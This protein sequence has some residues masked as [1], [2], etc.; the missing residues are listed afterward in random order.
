M[1]ANE[2][3]IAGLYM[4]LFVFM[5]AYFLLN[6]IL[7][8]ILSNFGEVEEQIA[9]EER[10]EAE[11]ELQRQ[12][13]SQQKAAS[14]GSHPP[15]SRSNTPREASNGPR[16]RNE[17]GRTFSGRGQGGDSSSNMEAME[18]SMQEREKSTF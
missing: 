12:L 6:L 8:V 1:D 5:S 4:T 16:S 13:E 9:E 3:I 2:P 14:D 7:A 15:A 17:K 11:E 18:E 10:E